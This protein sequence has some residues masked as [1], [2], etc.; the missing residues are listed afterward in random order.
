MTDLLK[1]LS[2]DKRGGMLVA[3][4]EPGHELLAA[5]FES[6]LDGVDDPYEELV[7]AIRVAT[8]TGAGESFSTNGF[9]VDVGS[10]VTTLRPHSRPDQHLN[11][12]TSDFAEA[13]DMYASYFDGRRRLDQS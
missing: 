12:S 2:L 11:V 9:S 3:V 13:L 5:Y 8:T 10:T 4:V 6:D 7:Q 1:Q